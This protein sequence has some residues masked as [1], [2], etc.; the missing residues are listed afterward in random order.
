VGNLIATH[1]VEISAPRGEVYDVIA[2]VPTSDIWNPSL[3]SVE[4]LESDPEGRAE[5]VEMKADALVKE[6]K[7]R[8]R[9]SYQP[10]EGMT[11]TQEKGDAKSLE[12]SWELVELEDGRTRATY[13]LDVDPGRIL[14]ML[15]RGPVEGKVKEFLSKGAAEG[16]KDHV[17]ASG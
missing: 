12:G 7:Q 16:L 3:K 8:V 4:V 15:L 10:P 5:L 1:T 9:F 11:W 2:D 14:G 6:T 17:E 13:T